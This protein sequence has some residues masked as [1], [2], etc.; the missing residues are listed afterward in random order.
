[1]T[2]GEMEPGSIRMIDMAELTGLRTVDCMHD[3]TLPTALELLACA[4]EL[5]PREI[6]IVGIEVRDTDTL[7][8][9]LTEP[10]A[11]AV[12]QAVEA[13]ISLLGSAI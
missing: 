7:D 1:M 11:K 3:A 6:S 9:N 4:G 8:E 10:V 12:P 13:V 5:L 2:T